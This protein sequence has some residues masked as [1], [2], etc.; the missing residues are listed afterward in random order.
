MPKSNTP[1]KPA[2]TKVVV[3]PLPKDDF[4]TQVVKKPIPFM[5]WSR[6]SES[7]T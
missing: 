2:T 4:Y 1:A 5:P 7:G 6:R 3:R